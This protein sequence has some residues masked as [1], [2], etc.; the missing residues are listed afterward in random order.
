MSSILII[1]D[2]LLFQAKPASE[3]ERPV[4]P[5]VGIKT[6]PIDESV[7]VHVEETSEIQLSTT[8]EH[9]PEIHLEPRP[10][11]I[12]PVDVQPESTVTV[13]VP[14]TKS[15]IKV[16]EKKSLTIDLHGAAVDLPDIELVTPGPLPTISATKVKKSSGGLCASCFG[17][18]S[19]ENVKKKK[20]IP[21]PIPLPS[22]PAKPIDKEEQKDL[23]PITEVP[24]V[25]STTAEEPILPRVNID[26][27]RERNLEKNGQVN[28]R[29]HRENV[30][31]LFFSLRHNLKIN[32]RLQ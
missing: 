14:S 27:F 12:E 16:T 24:S 8:V 7:S 18:K 20:S 3:Y 29:I 9:K 4:T 30:H 25:P 19:A 5:E 11:T 26:Q 31:F 23:S 21:Q 13:V 28:P 6:I 32:K 22:E 1:D 15:E 10:A 2:H 17:K